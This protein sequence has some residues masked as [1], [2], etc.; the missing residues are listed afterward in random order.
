MPFWN[1][2]DIVN[3]IGYKCIP[4]IF[5]LRKVL[6]CEESSAAQ[7]R[8]TQKQKKTIM[9]FE[10]IYKITQIKEYSRSGRVMVYY[11]CYALHHFIQFF[12]LFQMNDTKM[13][14]RSWQIQQFIRQC[15]EC[16][17]Q[18]FYAHG[19]HIFFPIFI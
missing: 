17:F 14:R 19:K 1:C 6:K 13:F 2:N 7:H 11:L 5:Y 16:C 12:S 18:A 8:N 15:Y 4:G 3:R 10:R 9:H